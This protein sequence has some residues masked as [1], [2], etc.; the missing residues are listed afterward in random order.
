MTT[1]EW[2][3]VSYVRRERGLE[4]ENTELHC[5]LSEEAKIEFAE[6]DAY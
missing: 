6:L 3:L 2:I 4:K 5:L 1:S